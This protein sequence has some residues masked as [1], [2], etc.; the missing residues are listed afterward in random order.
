M[1]PEADV[2]GRSLVKLHSGEVDEIRSALVVGLIDAFGNDGY[3][4][5]V[6]REGDPIAW[7]GFNG[8]ANEGVDLPY[9]VCPLH[10][11]G[12][13]GE[14]D[15]PGDGFWPEGDPGYIGG[16]DGDYGNEGGDLTWN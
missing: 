15:D 13:I 12:F 9:L 5:F 10:G 14:E 1:D 16:D 7:H 2:Q 4:Y 11:G 6:N 8:Y 3:V